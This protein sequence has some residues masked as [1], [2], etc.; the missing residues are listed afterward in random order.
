[1]EKI[2]KNCI[3]CMVCG[4]VIE[5]KSVHDFRT[6]SCGSCSVDGGLEY[7]RRVAESKESYTELSVTEE[8]TDIK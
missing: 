6:C 5:S 2:L 8:N 1:M 4:D 7:L 3:R